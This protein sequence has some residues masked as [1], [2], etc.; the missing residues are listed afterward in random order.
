[1]SHVQSAGRSKLIAIYFR[2]LFCFLKEIET[3][4]MILG[5]EMKY[6][7]AVNKSSLKQ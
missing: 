1:M 4:S 3:E 6:H 7:D 5:D 2:D